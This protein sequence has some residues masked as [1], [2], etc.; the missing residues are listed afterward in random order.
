MNPPHEFLTTKL[1]SS[2]D[3]KD[4]QTL[5]ANFRA[6]GGIFKKKSKSKTFKTTVNIYF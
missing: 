6:S 1:V 4:F 5:L 3:S 2:A